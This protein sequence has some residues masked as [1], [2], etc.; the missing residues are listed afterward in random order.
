MTVVDTPKYYPPGDPRLV[1]AYIDDTGKYVVDFEYLDARSELLC[2]A[3]LGDPNLFE[4]GE[5]YTYEE[6]IQKLIIPYTSEAD[7]VKNVMFGVGSFEP[8]YFSPN[9]ELERVV[10]KI[11]LKVD[12][13]SFNGGDLEINSIQICSVPKMSSLFGTIYRPDYDYN[14][15]FPPVTE[16]YYCYYDYYHYS[17]PFPRFERLY[18]Y[19]NASELFIDYDAVVDNISSGSTF[20]WYIPEHLRGDGNIWY[21]KDKYRET[22]PS[23]LETDNYQPG[24]GISYSTHIEIKGVYTDSESESQNVKFTIYLGDDDFYNHYNFDIYRNYFYNITV[25]IKSI[26]IN[27][28]RI[29][30]SPLPS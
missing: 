29:V 6:Y 11:Q 26:D 10:S 25:T 9:I 7:V 18:T 19:T 5:T 4:A 20:V 8:G 24:A 13:S 17:Q 14:Y 21:A 28:N 15:V 2:I 27:D 3:N 22:D 1:S 23:Y 30:L 12:Y 16:N